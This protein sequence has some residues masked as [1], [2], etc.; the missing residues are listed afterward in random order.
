MHDS[1]SLLDRDWPDL[2]AR[3]S[4]G[5]DLEALALEKRALVRRRG[6]PDAKALLRLAL[7]R[8]PGA[9][10]CNRCVTI[11]ARKSQD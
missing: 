10:A 7:A 3:L 5:L 6:V 4:K 9:F 1:A 8:G 11:A 2:L